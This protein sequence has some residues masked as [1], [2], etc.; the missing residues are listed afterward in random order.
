MKTAAAQLEPLAEA[1]D[2]Q[3]GERKGYSGHDGFGAFCVVTT[4]NS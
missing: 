1:Q 4:V 2:S 3:T